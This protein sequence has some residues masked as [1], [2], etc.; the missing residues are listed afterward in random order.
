MLGVGIQT[1][2][3]STLINDGCSILDGHDAPF[4]PSKTWES[5]DLSFDYR[6]ELLE[7]PYPGSGRLNTSTLVASGGGRV[8]VVQAERTVPYRSNNDKWRRR[9]GIPK[10]KKKMA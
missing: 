10:T 3:S 2:V 8:S 1:S 4:P 6:D 5:R 9:R 7:D